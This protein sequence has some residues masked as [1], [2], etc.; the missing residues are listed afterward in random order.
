MTKLILF[1]KNFFIANYNSKN[2]KIND[3]GNN[4]LLLL[5]EKGH[6]N[7]RKIYLMKVLFNNQKYLFLLTI[8]Y[9]CLNYKYL[10]II[11]FIIYISVDLLDE[12]LAWVYAFRYS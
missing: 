8:L 12:L 1:I 5:H 2:D 4:K 9:L 11:F 6:R 7:N 3:V 10:P